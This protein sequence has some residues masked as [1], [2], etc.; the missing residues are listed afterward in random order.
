M[1]LNLRLS[2]QILLPIEKRLFNPGFSFVVEL[3]GNVDLESFRATHQCQPAATRSTNQ[4]WLRFLN[5]IVVLKNLLHL[6][7]ENFFSLYIKKLN[8]YI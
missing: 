7:I 6:S 1:F 4:L 2:G 3:R 8:M 5:R